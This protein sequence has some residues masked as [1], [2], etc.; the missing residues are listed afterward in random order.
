LRTEGWGGYLDLKGKE[1]RSWRKLHNDELH[2]LYSSPNI[3]THWHALGREEVFTGFWLGGPRVRDHWEDL[4]V[5]VRITL[6]WT[7]GRQGPMGRTGFDW[8]GIG[9]SG[10][11]LW[12][13]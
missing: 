6:S 11:L 10:G 2:G 7:L 12:T 9:S 5:G 8:L 4:S 3:V 13:R 1:D